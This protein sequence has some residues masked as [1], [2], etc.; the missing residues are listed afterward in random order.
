M[1][2]HQMKRWLIAVGIMQIGFKR[3]GA[4][5]V[6][7]ESAEISYAKNISLGSNVHIGPR[8]MLDGS[9][10]ITIE[11]GVIIAPDVKIYSRTHNFNHNLKAVPFDNIMLVSPVKINRYVW[12]GTNVIILP[13]VEIGEGAVIGA[14]SV[15]S[16]DV[17]KCAVVAGNPAKTVG[18]RNKEMYDELSRSSDNFVYSKFGHGKINQTKLKK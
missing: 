6:I 5:A 11:E 8:V 7:H 12:I 4:G 13:G 18:E 14:G 9:G 2:R 10:G 17:P 15:V 3:R 16:R 1:I